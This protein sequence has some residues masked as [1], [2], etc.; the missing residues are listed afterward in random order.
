MK[1]GTKFKITLNIKFY[2][3]PIYDEKYIKTKLKTFN[4][5]INT[6]FSDNEIPKARNHA[7]CIT[8]ININSVMKV[9]KKT[10]LN[11]I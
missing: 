5:V 9:D 2:S 7:T 10:I 6:A 1:F 3:Q 8:A 11:F 4:D